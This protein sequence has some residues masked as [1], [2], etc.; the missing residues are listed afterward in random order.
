MGRTG[1]VGAE[2]RHLG[3]AAIPEDAKHREQAESFL[4]FLETPEARAVFKKAGF[5]ASV[6]P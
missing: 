6:L 3:H 5:D 1:P 4:V 2:L